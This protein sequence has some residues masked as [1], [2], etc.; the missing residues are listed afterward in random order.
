MTL[1]AFAFHKCRQKTQYLHQP[2]NNS[3]TGKE[4][5]III[6]FYRY[7]VKLPI[8]TYIIINL[9]NIFFFFNRCIF[10]W[11][12]HAR[13]FWRTLWRPSNIWQCTVSL[14]TPFSVLPGVPPLRKAAPHG[15]G[16][17]KVFSFFNQYNFRTK[18]QSLQERLMTERKENDKGRTL[19]DLSTTFTYITVNTS[20]NE[21]VLIWFILR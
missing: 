1:F 18:I 13:N 19:T 7:Q 17:N 9:L 21:Y 3:D 4:L 8:I 6:L 16:Q 10:G 14:S 5:A 11:W 20:L 15:H 2:L 12:W